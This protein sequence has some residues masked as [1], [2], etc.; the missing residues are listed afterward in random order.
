[1]TTVFWIKIIATAFFLLLG[2]LGLIGHLSKDKRG[3]LKLQAYVDTY[4]EKWGP[5]LH[6]LKVA[7]L[8]ILLGSLLILSIYT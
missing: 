6:F 1:M 4:G 8:P 7:V 5:K 2:V 3:F